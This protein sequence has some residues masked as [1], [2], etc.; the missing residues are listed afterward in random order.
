MQ[1]E[2]NKKIENLGEKIGFMF[3][4][5]LFTTILFVILLLLNKLPNRNYFYVMGITFFIVVIGEIIKRL[6]K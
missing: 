5:F 1:F 6:L 3:S 4:Y 2:Q